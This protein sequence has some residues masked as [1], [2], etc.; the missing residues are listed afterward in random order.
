MGCCQTSTLS[1]SEQVCLYQQN[2]N[3]SKS[4]SFFNSSSQMEHAGKPLRQISETPTRAH[5]IEDISSCFSLGNHISSIFYGNRYSCIHIPTD[6]AKEIIILKKSEISLKVMDKILDNAYKIKNQEHENLIKI[7]HIGEDD[8]FIKIV[9]EPCIETNL[10]DFIRKNI[11]QKNKAV[12]LMKDILRGIR[13]YHECEIILQYLTD[14]EVFIINNQA[15]ISPLVLL[16]ASSFTR[17]PESEPSQKSDV[18]SAGL[19]F[20]QMI[21]SAPYIKTIE[22][23]LNNLQD[24]EFNKKDLLL[25][26]KMFEPVSNRCSISDILTHKWSYED[27]NSSRFS[28]IGQ[29]K[30]DVPIRGCFFN[31]NSDDDDLENQ[32]LSD[33]D[34]IDKK[35]LSEKSYKTNNDIYH[36]KVLFDSCK[37]NNNDDDYL[38]DWQE[39]DLNCNGRIKICDI[40]QDEM[41]EILESCP[42]HEESSIGEKDHFHLGGLENNRISDENPLDKFLSDGFYI[43]SEKNSLILSLNESPVF[44]EDDIKSPEIYTFNSPNQ[45]DEDSKE[46][47]QDLDEDIL[48]ITKKNDIFEIF[49]NDKSLLPVS[50]LLIPEDNFV[51]CD[52]NDV[53]YKKYVYEKSSYSES[54]ETSFKTD[55]CYKK[56]YE[57]G[58]NELKRAA[59]ICP[60]LVNRLSR[61]IC[62]DEKIICENVK[63]K[64]KGYNFKGR[65][66]IVVCDTDKK[67]IFLYENEMVISGIKL[68]EIK[69]AIIRKH[70]L[71]LQFSVLEYFI[72]G[73]RYLKAVDI[74]IMDI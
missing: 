42:D 56:N 74:S 61:V 36:N 71:G 35:D 45:I 29:R 17:A 6:T 69:K 10:S 47:S 48:K 2:D 24:L 15:K 21:T 66:G 38:F 31:K 14:R 19:L 40:L 60:K 55:E 23:V 44:N 27:G 8:Q 73:V 13:V 30:P 67:E 62:D 32:S 49:T 64:I 46:A 63:G 72:K 12:N 65:F 28:M 20:L 57:G 50:S 70:Q 53:K 5:H 58:K 54:V 7:F 16:N 43:N 4:E 1:T 26:K 41:K 22:Q 11:I 18:W 37:K 34:V 52:F 68:R 25:I 3:V 39:I 9:T 51:I 59:S 33:E